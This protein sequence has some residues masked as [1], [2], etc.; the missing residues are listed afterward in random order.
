MDGDPGLVPYEQ[1]EHT[2]DLAY[3]ARGRTLEALFENAAAGLFSLLLDPGVVEPRD[4]E[5]IAFE[6]HD[7]EEMLVAWLQ[8]ILFRIMTRGRVFR[9]A[10]VRVVTPPRA[11]GLCRGEALDPTRHELAAEIK[12]VTYHG[13]SIV[14]GRDDAGPLFQ[15]RVVLDI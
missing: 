6:G 7:A 11:S 4:E 12:A 1:V 9:S 13:L 8:E 3:V 2:A 10:T 15:A 14:R 5:E